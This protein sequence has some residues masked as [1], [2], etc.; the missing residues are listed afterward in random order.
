METNCVP[1]LADLFLYSYKNEFLDKLIEE[2][3]RKLVR[4]FN[5]SYCYPDDLISFINKR[6]GDN[7]HS[8]LRHAIPMAVTGG[9]GGG[10]G[11]LV[12]R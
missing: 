5:L 1:L 11:R 7:V 4:K 9:G 8:H 2:G 6:F 3:K 10:G 12:E